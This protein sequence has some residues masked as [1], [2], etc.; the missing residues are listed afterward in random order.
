[1]LL[2]AICLGIKEKGA[3][4]SIYTT[5]YDNKEMLLYSFSEEKPDNG[6]EMKIIVLDKDGHFRITQHEHIFN[7]NYFQ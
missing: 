7:E 5:I 3:D 4:F 2:S 1:M 6:I